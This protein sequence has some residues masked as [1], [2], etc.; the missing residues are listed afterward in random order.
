MKKITLLAALCVVLTTNAQLLTE[1]FEDILT[2]PGDGWVFTNVSDSPSGTYFQGNDGVFAAFEGGPTEYIGVNFNSTEGTSGTETISNWMFL[3][4]LNLENDDI[5]TFYTQT[6]LGSAFPDRLEVRIDPTGADV[7][8]TTPTDVGSYTELLLSINDFL[9][10]GGYPEIWEEQIVTIVGLTG[11]TDTKIA[12]RYFV[13]DAG[14]SGTNSNYI[15]LDSLV[16]DES[17]GVDDNAFNGF[18]FFVD[19]NNQLNLRANVPMENVQL[20]NILGQNVLNQKL[21]NTN[22]VIT[23]STLKSGVYIA[24]VLIEGQSKSFKIVKR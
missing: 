17:L 6:I 1:G 18:T 9:D 14:P 10:P 3:P 7:L 16:V 19:A 21:S 15:G 20:F 12:F 13:T 4:Q 5:L 22:E 23:I 2:L 8:P 11:A 24:T